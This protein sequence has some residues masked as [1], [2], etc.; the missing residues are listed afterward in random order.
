MLFRRFLSILGY[1]GDFRRRGNPDIII[2]IEDN[3]Y[4]SVPSSDQL[5][6]K[7]DTLRS[8]YNTQ[9]NKVKASVG[10]GTGSDAI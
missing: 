8:Y 1:L 4:T 5:L 7:M 6:E 10:T 2:A 3:E 9:K